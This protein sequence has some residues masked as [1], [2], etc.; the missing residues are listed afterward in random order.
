MHRTLS[1]LAVLVIFAFGAPGLRAG[2]SES[3]VIL[4]IAGD[5]GAS[6]RSGLDAFRDGFLNYHE[7]T[8]KA[9][10]QFTRA[11]LAA[12]PQVEIVAHGA[13]EAWTKPVAL[14]GPLLTDVLARAGAGGKSVTLVALDGYAAELDPAAQSAQKWIL[15][16]SMDGKPLSLGGRGPLW[17]ARDTGSGKASEEELAKWVWSVFYIEVGMQ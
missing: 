15:A 11:E 7:K 13:S 12:L 14:K 9:A 2:Q 5:I 4:T 17:L 16:H 1:L 8:F 3:P 6:N 10:F